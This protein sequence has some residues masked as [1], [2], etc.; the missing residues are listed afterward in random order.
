MNTITKHIPNTITC[1][2]L[3]SGCIATYAG[4][5][6]QY[7]MAVTFILLSAVFDFFDGFTARW[8]HAYSPLGKELDSL[9]DLV[10][11]G[12][13]PSAMVFCVLYDSLPVDWHFLSYSAFF[14]VIFSALRLA[15]FNL[16]DRQATS[17]IG[18]PVPA[19]A[20]FWASFVFTSSNLFAAVHWE[21]VLLLIALFCYLLVAEL[22]MFSLKMKSYKWADNKLRF[23]FLGVAAVILAFSCFNYGSFALVI[24]LYILFSLFD[25]YKKK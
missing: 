11:F 5:D 21:I 15:K 19:N 14:I 18:L 20:I 24:S 1:C 2:N 22:P 12:L 4:F 13:A 10:S 3:F 8:L 6:G 16:D 23:S 17:F 7:A 9:A 25:F